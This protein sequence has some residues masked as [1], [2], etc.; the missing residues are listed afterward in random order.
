MGNVRCL[1][2]GAVLGAPEQAPYDVI[3]VTAAAPV[4]PPS[5]LQQLAPGGRIVVPVGSRHEQELVVA[6]RTGQGLKQ[7]TITRCA[8]VPLIGAEGFPADPRDDDGRRTGA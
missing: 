6:T 4:V 8:F 2:A 3:V 1:P 7:R 5:L